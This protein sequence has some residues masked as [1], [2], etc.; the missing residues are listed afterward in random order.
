MIAGLHA[1]TLVNQVVGKPSRENPSPKR[2]FISR[3][4]WPGSAELVG[5]KLST[6]K[7]IFLESSAMGSEDISSVW[8]AVNVRVPDQ[9]LAIVLHCKQDHLRRL[10]RFPPERVFDELTRLQLHEHHGS[11]TLNMFGIAVDPDS[12]STSP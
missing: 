7:S 5:A 12:V 8:I 11:A 9:A 1:N 3:Q 10:L 6:T 2:S 4:V